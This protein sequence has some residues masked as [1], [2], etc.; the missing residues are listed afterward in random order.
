MTEIIFTSDARADEWVS[1]LSIENENF[2]PSAYALG[3]YGTVWVQECNAFPFLYK[4]TPEE[5]REVMS[6]YEELD[7]DVEPNDVITILEEAIQYGG[8]SAS[9]V[10]EL[11]REWD[12]RVT[13][14]DSEEDYGRYIVSELG[15]GLPEWAERHFDFEGYGA[16][17]VNDREACGDL[18]VSG[19]WG[20]FWLVTPEA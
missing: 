15:E 10:G 17:C 18:K 8:Y 6:A 14:W 2:V 7:T 12:W 9:D 11:L 1:P 19:T 16:E 5:V 3:N 13:Q 4:M 20:A